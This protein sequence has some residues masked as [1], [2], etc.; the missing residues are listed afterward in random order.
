M[1]KT[2]LIGRLT[3]D[4]ELRY[5]GQGTPVT[6]FTLAINRKFKRDE[7]DFIPCVVWTK[8]AEHCANY[9]KKGSQCAVEGRI[10]TRNYENQEG[11]KVYV[12]E[13]V[14]EDVRF[15][16]SKGGSKPEAD[17]DK[18]AHLAKGDGVGDIN[19]D[20]VQLVDADDDVP[21]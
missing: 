7:T 5:T 8:L 13:V 18:W 10:Q 11:R 19:L 12:T 9:L 1:N 21:W 20:D 6:T 16:D 15:L 3:K 2:I 17:T 14:A 4:P